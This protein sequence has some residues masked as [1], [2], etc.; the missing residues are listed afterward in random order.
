[1]V[2]TPPAGAKKPVTVVVGKSVFKKAAER[3]LFK[4]RVRSVLIPIA[5]KESKKFWVVAKPSAAKLGFQEIK[6]EILSQIRN[7]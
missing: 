4:R 5:G 7:H 6:E 2:K 1:M 3:N